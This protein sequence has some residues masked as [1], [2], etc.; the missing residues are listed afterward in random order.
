VTRTST[1]TAVILTALITGSCTPSAEDV[2]GLA[3]AAWLV[4]SIG[5]EFPVPG[6]TPWVQF[7]IANEI[8]GN[9]GCNDFMGRYATQDQTLIVGGWGATSA[10][11][12][13]EQA[14]ALEDRLFQVLR[15]NPRY[16]L[17][18]GNLTIGGDSLDLVSLESVG[19]A[20]PDHG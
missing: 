18:G 6:R 14:E 4:T 3:G 17:N 12:K 7:T 8:E 16:L 2:D 5:G 10:S 19:N 11:C 15:R 13:S 1:L 20:E 9:G